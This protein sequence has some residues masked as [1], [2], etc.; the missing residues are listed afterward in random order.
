LSHKYFTGET[1]YAIIALL[2]PHNIPKLFE[3]ANLANPEGQTLIKL[4]TFAIVKL[5]LQLA[6]FS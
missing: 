1:S 6:D 3:D 5:T 4:V 2:L